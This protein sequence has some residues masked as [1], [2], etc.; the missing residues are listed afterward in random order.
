[1]KIKNQ[2]NMSPL[3]GN[4]HG[5]VLPDHFPGERLPDSTISILKESATGEWVLS[6][7]VKNITQTWQHVAVVSGNFL[8]TSGIRWLLGE[9]APL[10]LKVYRHIEDLQKQLL[11]EAGFTPDVVIWL[12]IKPGYSKE[13]TATVIRL[14]QRFP[15]LRQLAVSDRIPQQFWLL[16]RGVSI[17]SPCATLSELRKKLR[18]MFSGRNDAHDPLFHSEGITYRQWY[19]IRLHIAGYSIKEIASQMQM[20]T[21]RVYSLHAEVMRLLNLRG[22]L[23]KAWLY[24]SIQEALTA[25]GLE[26]IVTCRSGKPALT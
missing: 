9:Y 4:L 5:F 10:R 8:F 2:V 20:S 24:R 25:L 11:E 13:L 1:M 6:D 3:A 17:A 15:A 18:G 12:D 19:S 16:P 21:K 26:Q 14:C 7:P 23:H 22:P